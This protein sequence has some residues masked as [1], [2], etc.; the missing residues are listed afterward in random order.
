MTPN[1]FAALREHSRQGVRRW[2][3]CMDAHSPSL[4]SRSA[5][6][7]ADMPISLVCANG[8]CAPTGCADG[9]SLRTRNWPRGHYTPNDYLPE[10]DHSARWSAILPLTA[11][12]HIALRL[13]QPPAQLPD[14]VRWM[15]ELGKAS[16]EAP[17]PRDAQASRRSGRRTTAG[18]PRS[19]PNELA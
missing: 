11:R 18:F 10:P 19:T 9:V 5:P 15:F 2:S 16:G 4:L 1:V 17:R 3:G 6:S 14:R 13:S 8:S 12:P 7:S